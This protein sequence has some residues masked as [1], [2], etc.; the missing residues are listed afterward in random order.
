VEAAP[1][2]ALLGDDDRVFAA[3]GDTA[4]VG[5]SMLVGLDVAA[6]RLTS[7]ANSTATAVAPEPLVVG[8]GSDGKSIAVT[9]PTATTPVGFNLQVTC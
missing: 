7:R 8:I 6:H 5:A 3:A 9:E 4:R 2:R 1:R